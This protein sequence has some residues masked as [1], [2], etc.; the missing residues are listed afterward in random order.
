M[1]VDVIP[2]EPALRDAWDT[3]CTNAVNSTFL[4]TRRFLGYHGDRFNDVSA[5]LTQG[6]V[7][8]GVFAAAQAPADRAMVVSHPGITYGGVVHDG[9]LSG[10]KMIE[11][12]DKLC[13][14]YRGRGYERLRYKAV[15]H[16][17]Q[18]RPSQDDLY[19]LFRIGARRTRCDLSCAIDLYDRAKPAERRRRGLKKALKS[20]TVQAGSAQLRPLWG[21]LMD[22]LARKHDAAP[23]HSTEEMEQLAGLFPEAIEFFCATMDGRVEAG[24]VVF[25]TRTAWHAQYI[26]ASAAAYSVSALDAIFDHAIAGAKAAGVRYFDFGTSNESEGT[27]LNESLYQYKHEY[28]GGGAVHEFYDV[29]LLGAQNAGV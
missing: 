28:G 13:A 2:F 24:V 23:V 21:V 16:V 29:D 5:L 12:M 26:A 3:F 11:A 8:V 4:H 18:A 27:V 17:Y 9:A 1:T 10:G 15:P 20:V 7:I 14:H 25:K 22:N 19:A 6:G